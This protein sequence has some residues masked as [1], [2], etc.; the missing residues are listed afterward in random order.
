M[1]HTKSKYRPGQILRMADGEFFGTIKYVNIFRDE[2]GVKIEN[3][4][5]TFSIP[6]VDY[7]FCVDHQPLLENAI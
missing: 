7:I 5:R 2:I 6:F 1:S 4:Y 3:D